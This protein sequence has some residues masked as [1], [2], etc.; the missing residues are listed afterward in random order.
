MR[1]TR[2]IRLAFV[3][4]IATLLPAAARGEPAILH[5][6]PAAGGEYVLAGYAD[7]GHAAQFGGIYTVQGS[8]GVPLVAQPATAPPGG[9]PTIYLPVIDGP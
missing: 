4:L 5:T 3:A 9:D 7:P 2:P 1:Q 8:V 6:D